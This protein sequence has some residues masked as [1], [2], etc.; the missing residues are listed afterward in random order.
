MVHVCLSSLPSPP[1]ASPP[2]AVKLP[3]GLDNAERPGVAKKDMVL[4]R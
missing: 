4:L 1:C 2:P 3:G